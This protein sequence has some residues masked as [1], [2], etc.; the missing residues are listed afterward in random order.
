MPTDFNLY[1]EPFCGSAAIFFNYFGG[2]DIFTSLEGKDAVLN[3]SNPFLINAHTCVR[4]YLPQLKERLAWYEEQHNTSKDHNAFYK[5]CARSVNDVKFEGIANVEA[6]ALYIYLNKTAFNGLWRHNSAGRFNATW[7]KVTKINLITEHLDTS[8]ATLSQYA[9]MISNFGFDLIIKEMLE[10]YSSRKHFYFID[11]PYLALTKTANFVK[12]TK[13]WW[14][15]E[16]N[17]R[18]V[19][20][21][22]DINAAGHRFML[23]NSSSPAVYELFG[24]WNIVE[25]TASRMIRPKAHRPSV[26][27]TIITN[28]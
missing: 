3:D 8:A 13:D 9:H 6:A 17:Q 2:E 24:E 7:N 12:Y 11:P 21:L 28:Y 26:K 1:V 10:W 23:T 16:D 25:V 4:Y 14:T 20:R 18:L 19:Q 22:K 27:E 5:S 15:D